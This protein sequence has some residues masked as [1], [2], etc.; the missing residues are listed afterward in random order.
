M[1]DVNEIL[2]LTE[3]PFRERDYQRFGVEILLRNFTVQV[4]DCTAWLQPVFWE[5]Y[6]EVRHVFPGYLSIKDERVF[7]SVL[8]GISNRAVAIDYLFSGP[9]HKHIC[10]ALREH[11]IL[12]AIVLSGITPKVKLQGLTRLRGLLRDGR[13]SGKRLVY[14]LR[15][16]VAPGIGMGLVA[17]ISILS[18]EASLQN[19]KAHAQHQVWA[20]AFDY[21]LFLRLRDSGLPDETPYAVFLDQNLI[22]HSDLLLTGKTPSTNETGYFPALNRFFDK[23]EYRTGCRVLIATHP[24]AKYDLYSHLFCG[25]EVVA[26]RTAELVRDAKLVFAHYSTAISFP[27]L[28]RKPLVLLTTNDL[29]RCWVQPLIE[30][31][32]KCFCSPLVN[33]D[34]YRD[35]EINLS[36]W[37]R[38]PHAA[39]NHYIRR[40][41]KVPGTPERPLWEIFSD[42]IRE[43]LD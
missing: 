9:M 39:Y 42:Y 3:T 23:F 25:R 40:Y 24:R 5:K 30:A 19:Y 20:H 4:L 33:V 6:A 34:T 29:Q 13:D 28:W 16:L 41:V 10:H 43:K 14:Q 7:N 36:E 32:K 8:D 18:G 17:N 26:G 12:R 1:T 27:V 37:L 2:I 31:F 35:V 21:D 15:R 22:Y 11:N 38:V